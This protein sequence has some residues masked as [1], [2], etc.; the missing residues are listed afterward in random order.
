[1]YR[2]E[3]IAP[4]GKKI[5]LKQYDP[6]YTGAFKNKIDA[7]TKL[8]E[9]V[10]RLG[11][12]QDVLYA[13]DSHALLIVIQAMDAAGKDST[14]K[15]VMSG[16]NPQG[17]TVVSFKAPSVEELSHDFLWRTACALPA[18]GY[19]GIFNRSHYEEVLVVKVHPGLLEKQH[20][21]PELRTGDFW[22]NRYEDINCF[23]RYLS[24]NGIAILKF[25]LHVS[26]VEQRRRFL[27]RLNEPDKHWKFSEQD[28]AERDCWNDYM[29]AYEDVFTHT[30]TE[31][32]PW[33]IIPADHKWFT[34]TAVADIIVARLKDLNLHYPVVEKEQRAVLARAKKVLMQERSAGE[35]KR[36]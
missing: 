15:H 7:H 8:E 4:P 5:S 28:V 20:I 16:V 6:E 36:S 3:F 13:Q 22:K 17:C 9:D 32:A 34:R 21:P 25:F 31:W 11:E 1:M 10:R 35:P 24:R 14:I 19:I 30:S 18:R 26:Q 27:D 33:Y 29:K 23:E 2:Q 12:Y